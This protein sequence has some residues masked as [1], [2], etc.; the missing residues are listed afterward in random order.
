MA[1]KYIVL[2]EVEVANVKAFEPI[3][4]QE[5]GNDLQAVRSFLEQGDHGEVYGEGNYRAVPKRSWPEDPHPIHK[6]ISFG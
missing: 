1:T 6:K 3:G 2:R 4:E 5:A